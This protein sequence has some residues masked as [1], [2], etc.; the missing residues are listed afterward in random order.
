MYRYS[1]CRWPFPHRLT[2]DGHDKLMSALEILPE[3]KRSP[4]VPWTQEEKDALVVMY[5]KNLRYAFMAEVLDRSVDSV[6]KEIVFL[7]R[8]GLLKQRPNIQSVLFKKRNEYI[9]RHFLIRGVDYC[10]RHL[11]LA[12]STIEVYAEKLGLTKVA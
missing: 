5:K 7:H 10:V 6:R 12:K 3:G 11:G 4:I 9:K 8:D 2:G 1:G